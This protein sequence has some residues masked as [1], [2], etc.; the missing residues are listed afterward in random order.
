MDGS[1]SAA[2][3]YALIARGLSIVIL[4]AVIDIGTQ[5]NTWFHICTAP[6]RVFIRS[7]TARGR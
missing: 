5:L 3:E 6:V 1:A 4:A 7:V 2:I